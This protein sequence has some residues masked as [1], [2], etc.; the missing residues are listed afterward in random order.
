MKKILVL[1]ASFLATSMGIEACH[2]GKCAIDYVEEGQSVQESFFEAIKKNDGGSV[3]KW[4][5]RMDINSTDRRGWTPVYFAYRRATES[6]L[7]SEKSS[8]YDIAQAILGAGADINK[9]SGKN[10]ETVLHYL[11]RKANPYVGSGDN[12][13]IRRDD[14]RLH[15]STLEPVF[16]HLIDF[17]LKNGAN[18][19]VENNS[20]E[21]PYGCASKQVQEKIDLLLAEN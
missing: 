13:G 21:T 5:S 19:G 8:D 20:G 1:M 4:L 17:C 18:I 10:G 15:H 12:V 3:Q 2:Y 16:V 11:V 14:D 6:L 7:T 9:P